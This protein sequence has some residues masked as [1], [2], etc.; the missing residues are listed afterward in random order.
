[1]TD[2]EVFARNLRR[3]MEAN[4]ENQMELA[5]HLGCTSAAVSDWCLGKKMPRMDKVAAI[6]RH[7]NCTYTDLLGDMLEDNGEDTLVL[8][9]RV[10]SNGRKDMALNYLSF[11]VNEE[12]RERHE[13]EANS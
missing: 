7:Y 9:Y 1:M 5:R 11:L 4:N 10:L 13:K 12:T 6:S 2:R 8:F 3:Y